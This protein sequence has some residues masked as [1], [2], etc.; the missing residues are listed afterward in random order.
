MRGVGPGSEAPNTAPPRPAL[1]R[2]AAGGVPPAWHLQLLSP[3]AERGRGHSVRGRPG[4]CVCR[5]RAQRLPEAARGTSRARPL[6]PRPAL[7]A[8]LSLSRGVWGHPLLEPKGALR[9][10]PDAPRSQQ[11][12]W[13]VSEDKKAKCADKG[14]SKQ[15]GFGAAVDKH[16]GLSG[17]VRPPPA[18]PAGLLAGAPLSSKGESRRL[19]REPQRSRRASG[20]YL[21]LS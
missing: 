7:W 16:A 10:E 3:A 21:Q 17:S 5:Q 8:Q 1:P 18:A 19:L 20:T 12:S 6:R 13:K 15:V 11:A 4:S 2:G 14:K 9:T